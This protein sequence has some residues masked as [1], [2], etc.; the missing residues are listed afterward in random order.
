MMDRSGISYFCPCFICGV[1]TICSHREADL[2]G[3]WLL[4]LRDRG[5]LNETAPGPTMAPKPAA[6][7]TNPDRREITVLP[8]VAGAWR[9]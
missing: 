8:R 6:R 1:D 4:Q 7:E 3:W 2:V 9:R 5:L